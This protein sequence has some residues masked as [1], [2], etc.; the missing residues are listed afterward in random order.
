MDP[1]SLCPCGS[2][3]KLKFCC[4]DLIH[5]IERIHRM[6]EGDQPRAALRHVEQTLAKKPGRSSLLDLQAV[7]QMSLGETAAARETIAEFLRCDPHSPSAHALHALA[8][9]EEDQAH[10]AIDALQSALDRAETNIP[11]R[12]V[13]AIGAVAMACFHAG[14]VVASRAHLWLYQTFVGEQDDRALDLLTKMNQLKELPLLLRDQRWLRDL[15]EGHPAAVEMAAIQ[16]LALLGKWRSAAAKLDELLPDHLDEPLFFYNRA[17]LSGFLADQKNYAAGMR[18]YARQE[19]P[20]DDAVEAEALAQLVDDQAHEPDVETLSVIYNVVDA[21]RLVERLTSDK[22]I[23]AMPAEYLEQIEMDG[24]IPRGLYYLLDRPA[25][26]DSE[27]LAREQIPHV[28]AI[29][30]YY[31]RQTDRRERLELHVNRDHRYDECLQLL[32][33]VAGDAVD[34]QPE[35]YLTGVTSASDP[36]LAWRWYFPPETP[37]QTR[38]ELTLQEHRVAIKDRWPDAPRRALGGKTPREAAQDPELKLPLLAMILLL[39]QGAGSAAIGSVFDELREQLGLPARGSVALGSWDAAALPLVRVPRV[40]LSEVS[41]DDLASLLQRAT[42]ASATLAEE[43]IIR[44]ALRRP[45]FGEHANFADLYKRLFLLQQTP[46][47]AMQVVNEAR[48]W[49]VSQG[50]SCGSWDLVELQLLITVENDPDVA[51][52]VLKHLIEEHV[53]EEDIIRQLYE[54][55]HM[56]GAFPEQGTSRSAPYKE[57][58]AAGSPTGSTIWTPD[59]DTAGGGASKLWTPD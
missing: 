57:P 55:L 28:L 43:R 42:F 35:E 13:E 45:E 47:D 21:D 22:R 9:A 41:T 51:N 37:R 59:R 20:L 38:R 6:I 32:G 31:G 4:S 36:V 18:L 15:P 27:H 30:G 56:L 17:L 14:D 34:P 26:A 16:R 44:E 1:Y 33:D 58:V 2:G 10:E 49:T 48:D 11:R 50:E 25:L 12:V 7:L 53:G 54:F 29:I 24:V 46:A 3:K 52:R 40:D 19:V 5:E 8:L 39:E 23:V